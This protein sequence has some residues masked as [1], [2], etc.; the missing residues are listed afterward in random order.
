MRS[1]H[2]KVRGKLIKQCTVA[3]GLTGPRPGVYT[4]G[5]MAG[6]PAEKSVREVC[7]TQ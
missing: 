5:L 4:R 6:A 7:K 2:K 3:P 1:Q